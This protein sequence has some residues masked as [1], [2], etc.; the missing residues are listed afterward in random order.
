MRDPTVPE[1]AGRYVYCDNAKCDIYAAT[2]SAGSAAGDGPTGLHVA[3]LSGFGEDA[4]GRVYAAS[5]YGPG[6][7][8]VGGRAP[9][10]GP[11]PCPRPGGGLG[12]VADA[13]AAQRALV[14]A[15]RQPP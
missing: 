5:L 15:G 10:P 3:A 11:G 9:G 13:A 8:S 4:A 1:L 7:P 2:L 14:A 6:Y 12:P